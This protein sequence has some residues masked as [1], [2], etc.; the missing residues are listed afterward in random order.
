LKGFEAHHLNRSIQG[1]SHEKGGITMGE[2]I[3]W[4]SELATALKR[5][6]AEGNSILLSF[7][8]PG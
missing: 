2:K 6:K 3:N 4:E 8:N 7:H 1:R 5:A